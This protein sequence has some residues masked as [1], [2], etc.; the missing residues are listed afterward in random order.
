MKKN[1]AR[2]ILI[3]LCLGLL[4]ALAGCVSTEGTYYKYEDGE[5]DKDSYIKLADGKWSDDDDSEG[6]YTI[7]DGKITF[8]SELFGKKVEIA[9]GTIEK[10]VM[11]LTYSEMLDIKVTYCQEGQKPEA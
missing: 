9:S 8:F 4:T 6:T 2:L 3:V 7:E 5:Y 11:V 1:I 10:G